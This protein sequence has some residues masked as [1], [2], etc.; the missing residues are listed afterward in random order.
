MKKVIATPKRVEGMPAFDLT[1]TRGAEVGTA[2]R[3]K[4]GLWQV[5]IKGKV[6]SKGQSLRV[7]LGRADLIAVPAPK[8]GAT[9]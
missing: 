9:S 8:K 2:C 3:T 7:A 4:S 6:V 5:W 1:G